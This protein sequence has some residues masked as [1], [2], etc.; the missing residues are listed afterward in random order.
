VLGLLSARLRV[1]QSD[2][3]PT[4]ACRGDPP[5]E[6]FAAR[7]TDAH[8]CPAT[9]GPAAH[10]GGP[11]T[12][13]GEQTVRIGGLAAARVTDLATCVGGP[14]AVVAGSLTTLIGGLPAARMGD[15]TVHGGSVVA[16][17]PTVRIGDGGPG[18]SAVHRGNMLFIIDRNLKT[19]KICG[20]QEFSGFVEP[21][22]VA[23]VTKSINDV[24]SGKTTIDGNAYQ[25]T[26]LVQGRIRAAATEASPLANQVTVS[27][28]MLTP[29][30]SSQQDPA[31]VGKA[32][33]TYIHNNQDEDGCLVAPH[34]FGHTMGLKD[35]YSEGPP[36]PDGTRSVVRTG[37]KGGLMGDISPGSK[38]TSSNYSDLVH[39]TGL[40]EL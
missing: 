33:V 28:S 23:R 14:D 4:Q 26:S 19:I 22:F 25:V 35:E 9:T 6:K 38:P 2:S 30:Q 15:M 20:V 24:W 16:G 29:A 18:I 17:I 37:P 1:R 31:H 10:V 7:I 12:G 34:E 21:G 40:R 5:S 36:N 27:H 32:N 8:V 3:I 11:I 13:P 39:G